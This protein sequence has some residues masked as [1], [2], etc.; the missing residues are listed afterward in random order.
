MIYF[1]WYAKGPS[2]WWRA[3]HIKFCHS[4][5]LDLTHS[6]FDYQVGGTVPT[7]E[8]ILRSLDQTVGDNPERIS[9]PGLNYVNESTNC[10]WDCLYLILQVLREKLIL[11]AY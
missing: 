10:L 3:L 6:P 8:A 4:Q 1:E 5:V 11:P 9:N 2:L 7:T